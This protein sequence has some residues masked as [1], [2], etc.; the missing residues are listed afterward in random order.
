MKRRRA[1]G[2]DQTRR[3]KVKKKYK[4]KDMLGRE[5]GHDGCCTPDVLIFI[6]GTS[7][8]FDR[9]KGKR[10]GRERRQCV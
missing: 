9:G 5:L 4:K 10:N 1:K 7:K 3:R 6:G 2:G 8:R